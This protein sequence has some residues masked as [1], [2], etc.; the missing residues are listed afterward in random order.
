M[1]FRSKRTFRLCWGQLE[2]LKPCKNISKIGLSWMKET[3]DFSFWQRNRLLK[4]YGIY[5][6]SLKLIILLHFLL[7]F[8]LNV[9]CFKANF[10]FI[11]PD[12][13]LNYTSSAFT[14]F[15]LLFT[16]VRSFEAISRAMAALPNDLPAI[17]KAFR[18]SRQTFAVATTEEVR[19][20]HLALE[21]NNCTISLHTRV[22]LLRSRSRNFYTVTWY[23]CRL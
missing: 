9:L 1:G 3:L 18:D 10:C 12:Y 11:N 16:T 7:I 14:L 19:N 4:W 6:L 5:L 21:G 13:T 17:C 8:S 23:T 20:C 22:D 15:N 2:R